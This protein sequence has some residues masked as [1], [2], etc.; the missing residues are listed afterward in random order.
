L[1]LIAGAVVAVA[2]LCVGAASSEPSQDSADIEQLREEI[3]ALHRR[4]D[5]L[6]ERLKDR[7]LVLPREDGRQGPILIDPREAPR[8]T[9]RDWKPFEFNGMRFYVIPIENSRPPTLPA[10]K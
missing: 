6:E 10:Q 1:L 7:A 4:M 5:S 3:A 8:Q 9:P 2:A